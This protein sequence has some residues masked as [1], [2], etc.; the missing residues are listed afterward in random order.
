MN[1]S[2]TQFKPFSDGETVISIES[3][4]FKQAELENFALNAFRTEG[5]NYLGKII[6]EAGRGQFSID[7]PEN[8]REACFNEGLD[9]EI[10]QPSSQGWRKGKIRFKLT[11][12]FCPDEPELRE[13]TLDS[14][15]QANGSQVPQ[16][17][18]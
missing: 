13:S 10:L 16:S 4:M 3:N 1:N 7:K 11:L 14:L 8:Y 5:L 17:I 12:E 18:N 9:C 15:R 2:N 6:W